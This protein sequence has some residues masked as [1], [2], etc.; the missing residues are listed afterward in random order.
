M[1]DRG[2]PIRSLLVAI[3]CLIAAL[4]LAACGGGD[5]DDSSGGASTEDLQAYEPGDETVR[6]VDENTF[7]KPEPAGDY[8]IG[9]T[10]PHLKDEYWVAEAWGVD[11]EAEELGVDAEV[12]AAGGYGDTATQIDQIETFLTQGV[13]A[14]I[15]GAV[16]SEGVAPTVDRAWSEGVPVIYANALAESEKV[17]G[18]FTDDELAGT[19]QADF[20]AEEDPNAK[21][22]AMCGPPGVVWPKIRCESFIEQLGKKAPNA[23]ILSKKFHDMDRAVITD[24]ASSTLQGAQDATWV[25]NSTD[26]Q[27]KGVVDALRA[28]GEKP[29]DIGITNLTTGRELVDMLEEGWINFA[30]AERPVLQGRLAVDMAV[31]ILNGDQPAARWAV[32]LPGYTN[33]QEDIDRWHETEEELNWAPEDYQP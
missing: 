22:I 24:V 2:L 13:D 6:R 9:V 1:S 3:G 27:A 21:V 26:L 12:Q 15:V 5:G 30:L 32:D 29:G 20:L 11:Q 18:V 10:F 17:T 25:Y 8:T 16:D 4:A 31:Q 33:S 7:E 28:S 23:Q 14:L 19:A